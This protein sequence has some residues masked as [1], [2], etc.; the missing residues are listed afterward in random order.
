M[1]KETGM[2]RFQEKRLAQ[3]SAIIRDSFATEV[4][5]AV[6]L[7]GMDGF[8]SIYPASIVSH[9]DKINTF[10][11]VSVNEEES[12]VVDDILQSGKMVAQFYMMIESEAVKRKYHL[13]T[14]KS[15]DSEHRGYDLDE[16]IYEGVLNVEEGLPEGV[17]ELIENGVKSFLLPKILDNVI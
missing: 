12:F 3:K 2:N 10:Q 9:N 1:I 8:K 5:N 4:V 17:I 15:T 14:I 13:V 6:N 7:T 16:L 11:V